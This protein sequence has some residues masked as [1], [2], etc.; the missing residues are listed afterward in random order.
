[1]T[2]RMT[3][4]ALAT[5]I[6]SA[7]AVHAGTELFMKCQAKSGTIG[8][9]REVLRPCGYGKRVA[10]GGG[11]MFEQITGYCRR[12]KKF[13]YLT[14]TRENLSPKAIE[15]LGIDNVT[16][17]PKPLGEVWDARTGK[18]L[19]IHA[20]PDCKGPFLEITGPNELKHCPAC[21][22]PHFGVDKSEPV[23]CFD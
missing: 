13:V 9:I 22:K 10:F 1:M 14:W 7:A 19:T 2:K 3:F 15:H 23:M 6:L 11:V 21:N 20:C 12:C 18:V 5:C 16:P 4:I 17:A 8:A